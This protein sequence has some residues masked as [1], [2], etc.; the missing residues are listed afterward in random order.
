MLAQPE[1]AVVIAPD[2]KISQGSRR[3]L[4][5]EGMPASIFDGNGINFFKVPQ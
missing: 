5:A 1:M 4:T 2:E 3:R